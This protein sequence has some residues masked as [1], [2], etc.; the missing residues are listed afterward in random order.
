MVFCFINI[1][2]LH[3]LWK[4][5]REFFFLLQTRSLTIDMEEVVLLECLI[6]TDTVVLNFKQKVTNSNF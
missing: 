1:F 3:N 6:H 2:L 4:L 5:Y